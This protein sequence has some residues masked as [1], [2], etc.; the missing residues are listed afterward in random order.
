MEIFSI[1]K[2][3]AYYDSKCMRNCEN[4]GSKVPENSENK[5]QLGHSSAVIQMISRLTQKKGGDDRLI[6]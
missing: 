5:E 2:I 3:I 6:T 1:S 4:I